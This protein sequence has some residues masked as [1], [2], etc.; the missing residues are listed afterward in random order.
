MSFF[1]GITLSETP[2]KCASMNNKICKVRSEIL[3]VMKLYFFHLVLKQGNAVVVVTISMIH[4][5]KCFFQMLLKL[6]C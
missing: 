2:L 4:M 3:T 1:S 5:Q 6:K